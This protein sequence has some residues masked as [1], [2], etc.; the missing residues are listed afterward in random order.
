MGDKQTR[1]KINN[2]A[3]LIINNKTYYASE[4]MVTMFHRYEQDARMLGILLEM[5]TYLNE[6][7]L[8][9]N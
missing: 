5:G 9:V 8:K 3:T 1:S 4:N 2:M 7:T 6:L